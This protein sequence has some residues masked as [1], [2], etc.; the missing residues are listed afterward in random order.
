MKKIILTTA[1]IFS[2]SIACAQDAKTFGFKKNDF[3]LSGNITSVSGGQTAI[4]P[5]MAYFITDKVAIE[6][7]LS[8]MNGGG[9]SSSIDMSL[10]ARYQMLR[11]G[12][13]FIVFGNAELMFGNDISTFNAGVHLNY[14]LTQRLSMGWHLGD[15]LSYSRTKSG[16]SSTAINLN[17]YS[18]IFNT[19]NF[20]LEYIF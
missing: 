3:L 13:R 1:A 11:L 5:K 16:D 14:F 18:N 17:Q 12:E 2:L 20:S 19:A 7:G 9:M 8:S 15:L 10:G 4:S 6:A